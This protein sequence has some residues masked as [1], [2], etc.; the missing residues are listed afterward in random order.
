MN[1]RKGILPESFSDQSSSLQYMDCFSICFIFLLIVLY[2]QSFHL[3]FMSSVP[4]A[5]DSRRT[6][7]VTGW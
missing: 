2:L 6:Q 5:Q 3:T 7:L 4:P 1:E